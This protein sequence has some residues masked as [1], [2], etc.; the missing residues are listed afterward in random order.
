MFQ[1]IKDYQSKP[2]IDLAINSYQHS[3]RAA[4]YKK[5]IVIPINVTSTGEKEEEPLT[6]VMRPSLDHAVRKT[7]VKSFKDIKFTNLSYQ[8]IGNDLNS[9]P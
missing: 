8:L 5:G 1:S 6:F 4:L 9:K 2:V 7:L 3:V